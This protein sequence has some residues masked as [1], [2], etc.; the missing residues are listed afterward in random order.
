MSENENTTSAQE[1]AAS[2]QKIWA[3]TIIK[4]MQTASTITPGSPPPEAFRH[5]R[6]GMLNAL[7]DSWDQFLRSPQFLEAMKQS[8]DQTTTFRKMNNELLGRIRHELQA[9]SRDDIDNVMLTAR[10]MEKRLLDRIEK[11]S[12]QLDQM[13]EALKQTQPPQ[14]LRPGRSRKTASRQRVK[15]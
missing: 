2:F 15:R 6:G 11:L 9:P 3:D 7:A 10:H 1:Q 8:M 13:Q 4:M 5:L 12:T 14:T